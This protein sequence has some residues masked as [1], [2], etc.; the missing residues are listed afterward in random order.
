M[1]WIGYRL[2]CTHCLKNWPLRQGCQM[3]YLQTKTP[4]FGTF[5]TAW[6]GI[7]WYVHFTD[8]LY[9]FG[10]LVYFMAILVSF[11]VNWCVF[12]RLVSST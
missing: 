11:V 2:F 9:T 4:N 3:E 10:H 5:L 7:S 8:I 1:K 6:N 12:Y